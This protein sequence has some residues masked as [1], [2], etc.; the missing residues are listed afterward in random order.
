MFILSFDQFFILIIIL[1][2]LC[3][4][5]E[6]KTR[7]IR[8]T[9]LGYFLIIVFSLIVIYGLENEK[10]DI[11][12]VNS[13]SRNM[14]LEGSELVEN[15]S[16]YYINQPNGISK[17]VDKI[18]LKNNQNEI[19]SNDDSKAIFLVDCVNEFNLGLLKVRDYY[20]ILY[21]DEELYNTY[22]SKTL[23]SF[24]DYIDGDILEDDGSLK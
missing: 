18:V 16:L 14:Y 11:G 5:Y 4:I 10:S 22:Y 19:V 12:F 15:N 7:N 13:V 3:S 21:L 17:F 23:L 2:C 20:N 9:L 6:I 24:S 1:V 8:N